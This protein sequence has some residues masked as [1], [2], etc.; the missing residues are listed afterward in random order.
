M[1][2]NVYITKKKFLLSIRKAGIEQSENY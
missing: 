1:T 2:T